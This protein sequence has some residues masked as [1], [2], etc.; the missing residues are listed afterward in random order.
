MFSLGIF[1][2]VFFENKQPLFLHKVGWSVVTLIGKPAESK[3]QLFP[4]IL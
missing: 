4:H 3:F 1:H 2:I